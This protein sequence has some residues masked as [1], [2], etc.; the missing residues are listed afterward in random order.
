M[1]K[2]RTGTPYGAK[3]IRSSKWLL[4]LCSASAA[5]VDTLII[6]MLIAGGE[7]G[8]YLAC[9]FLLL[10]F[11]LFYFAV[12][13]FFTN[14]RFKYSILV[15]LSY[16]VLYTVGMF[17]GMAI[18]LGD[19]SAVLSSAAFALWGCVHAFNIVCAVVCAL[20][21]S[22]VIK[23]AWFAL[24][25]AAVFIV[26]SLAY[27]GFMF[28]DGYFGQGTGN[29]TLMYDYYGDKQ[30]YA[31]TGVLAGRSDTITVPETFNGKPVTAVSCSVFREKG[32]KEFNLSDNVT[33]FIDTNV[34]SRGIDMTGKRINVDKKSVND[35]REKFL[36]FSGGIY[37]ES[38]VALAN[39]TLPV[40]LSENE[41]YVAFNYEAAAVN[42]VRS[43]VIPVYVGDLK[44]FDIGTYTAGYDYVTHCENGSA[45]N[46]YWAYNNGG[47]VL[48]DLGVSGNVTKSTVANVKFEKV[49][50]VKVD[51][52]NDT[53]YDMRENEPELFD[54]AGG[55]SDYKYLTKPMASTLLNGL[56][57]RKGFTCNW[58]CDGAAFT[59]LT[60]VLADGITLSAQ[61]ELIKPTLALSASAANN[62]FTYGEDVTVFS[63]AQIEADGVTL[64]YSWTLNNGSQTWST[65][66]V[67]LAHPKPSEYEGTYTLL[68]TVDG[69][70]V[71][72][73]AKNVFATASINLKINPK[74]VSVT[75]QLPEDR[76]Y[77]GTLKNVSVSIDESQ[78]VAGDP[79]DYTCS[80]LKNFRNAG[81]YNFTVVVDAL[82]GMNYD[83]RNASMSLVIEPRPVTVE[84]QNYEGLVYNGYSQCPTATAAGVGGDGALPVSVSGGNRNAGTYTARASV[85]N[86][87][88]TL[89]D[90]AKTFTIVPKELYV[91][92]G[93]ATVVY[94]DKL[95]GA[96]IEF[97]GF[98]TG[99][100]R[101]VFGNIS[102]YTVPA[103]G[104]AEYKVGT[105]EKGVRCTGLNSGNYK[106][107]CTYGELT[108]IQRA[109]SIAWSMPSDLVYDGK[110]KN[111]TATVANKVA[112]DGVTLA[113]SGGNGIT[114]D[115]YTATVTAITG[116]D[117][118]N[119]KL[120][121]S[122]TR[123]Y[124]IT[125]RT[126]TVVW[127]LPEAPVYDGEEHY[128]V[129]TVQNLVAGDEQYLVTGFKYRDAGEYTFDAVGNPYIRENYDLEN[130]SVGFTVKPAQS[131]I[132]VVHV[133][134]FGLA[135]VTENEIDIEHADTLRVY[136]NITGVEVEVYVGGPTNRVDA[137]SISFIQ[138]GAYSFMFKIAETSNYS[139]KTV[140]LKVNVARSNVTVPPN[141]NLEVA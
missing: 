112:G 10:I 124:A 57:P 22:R 60:E 136:C 95:V 49:Y 103:I 122:V 45:D 21:A 116:A 128:V 28:A 135:V 33:T 89:T 12:S 36:R 72:S 82:T 113:V 55:I 100:D 43:N 137:D 50:R 71:T 91:A 83:V 92:V 20:F 35:F 104:D 101:S 79:V 110:P 16:V 39:A 25:V 3:G 30:H 32:V 26:G 127:N 14:F 108:L 109:V 7:G 56:K 58:L 19:G 99:D 9:P 88:Y 130:G 120:P 81:T 69:G 106:V 44:N 27:A 13:L 140:Y 6:A 132:S 52:G 17:I 84:W 86:A 138:A 31:V 66:N 68:V 64:K 41:G 134:A 74:P 77:D 96:D 65:E 119:Y 73:C 42:A 93:D 102:F 11:D 125:K 63:G 4:L 5:A 97:T 123:Q 38:A 48:T 105:Y 90:S 131:E 24:A 15:W 126:A 141:P 23:K 78:Q 37:S 67:S 80:G 117:A 75:W 114:V 111:V 59:D 51:N 87:N 53:K 98:A 133:S 61:W 94:G 118:A 47:Y 1:I 139:G 129:Y 40:N 8:E 34:L 62:T 70:D 18:N 29:R 85:A 121:D 2:N 107:L 76:V 54:T 46:Y 115:T